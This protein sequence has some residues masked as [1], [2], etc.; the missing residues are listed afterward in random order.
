MKRNVTIMPVVLNNQKVNLLVETKYLKSILRKAEKEDKSEAEINLIINGNQ[1]LKFNISVNK[2]KILLL[3]TENTNNIPVYL[4]NYIVDFTSQMDF[5]KKHPI[6]GRDD[7]IKKI[8]FYLSQ[9]SKNNVFLVGNKDVG[10][11]TI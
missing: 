7:E 10:K 4:S 8:W 11:T 3:K 1:N 5:Y 2:L 6:V 9:K